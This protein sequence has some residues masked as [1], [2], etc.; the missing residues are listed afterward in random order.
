MSS[1][2]ATA[3][4]LFLVSFAFHIQVAIA[5]MQHM[6]IPSSMAPATV[7]QQMAKDLHAK[8]AV[9]SSDCDNGVLL[10]LSVDDRQVFISTGAGSMR[11]L[12][13]NSLVD[14]I[15]NMKPKLR[16]QDFD[17]ALEQAVVDIG[18]GLAGRPPAKHTWEIVPIFFF[19]FVFFLM[20]RSW[21]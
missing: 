11:Y 8:W 14:I 9:G 7:A 20:G 18:L 2:P 17:G 19:A 4:V 12:S 5:L 15:S 1:S 13:D 21:W 6:K 10:L 3:S 16:E